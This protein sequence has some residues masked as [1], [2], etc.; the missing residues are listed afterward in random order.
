MAGSCSQIAASEPPGDGMRPL[1]YVMTDEQAVTCDGEDVIDDEST[2]AE[3]K[4]MKLTQYQ[5]EEPHRVWSLAILLG[6][7][8]VD[9]GKAVCRQHAMVQE[10]VPH[11]EAPGKPITLAYTQWYTRELAEWAGATLGRYEISTGRYRVKQELEH[12]AVRERLNRD[13]SSYGDTDD[14]HNPFY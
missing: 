7:L 6:R 14:I 12:I 11:W 9:V 3:A 2:E 10:G 13:I 8:L 4:I 5:E 1:R